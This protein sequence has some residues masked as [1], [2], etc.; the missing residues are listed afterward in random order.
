[1][2]ATQLVACS[3]II[4]SRGHNTDEEDFKQIIPKQST[5]DDVRAILGSPSSTS[6]FGAPTWYYITAHKETFGMLAPEITAQHVY[7]IHFD[8]NHVVTDIAQYT[9]DDS[10]PVAL[11]RKTT[12]SEG[13]EITFIQQLFGNFGRFGTPGRTINPT[14]GH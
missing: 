4:D 14:T 11:V 3:P 6:N 9:K 8:T 12:P 2:I 10:K 5:E 1:M 13:N 7:A